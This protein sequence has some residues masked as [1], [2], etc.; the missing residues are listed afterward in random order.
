MVRAASLAMR[1]QSGLSLGTLPSR[2]PLGSGSSASGRVCRTPPS[3]TASGP[4]LTSLPSRSFQMSSSCFDGAVPI[5]PAHVVHQLH[6]LW[7]WPQDWQSKALL[8]GSMH[9]KSG[10]AA[11]SPLKHGMQSSF[12]EAPLYDQGLVCPTRVDQACKAHSGD[13]PGRC[14]D[15]CREHTADYDVMAVSGDR[16]WRHHI[17]CEE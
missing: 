12:H 10:T 7:E 2:A 1:S 15:A 13:V 6:A 14:I 11:L 9:L 4:S 17:I 5:R 16:H 3:V 8:I